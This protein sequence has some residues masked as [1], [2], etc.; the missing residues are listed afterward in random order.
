MENATSQARRRDEP[1][2]ATKEIARVE[3]GRR[4]NVLQC[5]TAFT[6]AGMLFD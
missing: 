6:T 3:F 5:I 2:V 1:R 4:R